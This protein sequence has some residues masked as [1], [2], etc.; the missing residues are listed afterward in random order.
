MSKD[1]H[2]NGIPM[3]SDARHLLTERTFDG[4]VLA[5]DHEAYRRDLRKMTDLLSLGIL[6]VCVE[7]GWTQ[8]PINPLARPSRS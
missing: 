1:L 3:A 2:L 7:C 4:V 6:T 8:I 5:F